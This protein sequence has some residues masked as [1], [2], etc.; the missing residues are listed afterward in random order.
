MSY[1]QVN[2]RW[3][4]T[5]VRAIYYKDASWQTV[6][7]FLRELINA[8]YRLGLPVVHLQEDWTV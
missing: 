6:A 5:N 2:A 4:Q 1:P 8:K 3:N 7:H